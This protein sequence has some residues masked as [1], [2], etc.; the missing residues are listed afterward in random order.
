MTDTFSKR[1]FFL[2]LQGVWVPL[3]GLA[4]KEQLLTTRSNDTCCTFTNTL[5]VVGVGFRTQQRALER[6]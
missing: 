6:V 4:K 3:R 2:F 1:H 5:T